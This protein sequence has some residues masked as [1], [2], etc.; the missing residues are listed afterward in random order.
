MMRILESIGF[1][2]SIIIVLAFSALVI[3]ADEIIH[4]RNRRRREADKA[5]EGTRPAH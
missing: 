5:A 3:V 2:E 1:Y 4:A